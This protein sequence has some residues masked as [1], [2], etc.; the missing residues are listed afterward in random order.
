ML[1]YQIPNKDDIDLHSHPKIKISK[2]DEK[3]YHPKSQNQSNKKLKLS[4]IYMKRTTTYEHESEQWKK[5]TLVLLPAKFKRD[6]SILRIK[7][8]ESINK[9]DCI[10]K[11]NQGNIQRSNEIPK[12]IP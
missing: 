6:P 10:N 7:S 4:S 12:Y 9:P 5:N 2:T 3:S 11:L 8:A 1:Q